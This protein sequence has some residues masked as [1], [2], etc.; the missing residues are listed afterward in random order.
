[1]HAVG[2]PPRVPLKPARRGTTL[3]RFHGGAAP[4]VK[5]KALERLELA[6]DRMARELLGI[7]TG[8]ESEAVKLAAVQDALDRAGPRL[9]P[10]Y[11]VDR[12]AGGRAGDG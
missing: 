12:C 7:A 11:T 4:Q 5:A 10:G 6:A 3:C 2:Q 1:V 9:R 8:A